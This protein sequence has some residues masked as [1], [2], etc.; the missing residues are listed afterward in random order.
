MSEP[1]FPYFTDTSLIPSS[2]HPATC[3]SAQYSCLNLSVAEEEQGGSS[4]WGRGSWSLRLRCRQSRLVTGVD[5][6]G[7]GE[8]EGG[9]KVHAIGQLL[10]ARASHRA[11]ST[12]PLSTRTLFPERFV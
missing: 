8:E 2:P 6:V 4:E 3:F 5:K 12:T 11:G 10:K 1:L 7:L 9:Q